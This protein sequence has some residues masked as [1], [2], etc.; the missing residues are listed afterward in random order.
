M[1]EDIVSFI[2]NKL[3]TIE[4]S[5][6]KEEK[7]KECYEIFD[8]LINNKKFLMDNFKFAN[9]VFRKLLEMKKEKN[10]PMEDFNERCDYY[11][12]EFIYVY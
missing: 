3:T 5:F 2:R 12:K 9:T 11:L 1:K 8:L 7:I 10:V 6:I 4:N